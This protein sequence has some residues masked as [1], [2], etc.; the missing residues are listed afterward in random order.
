MKTQSSIQRR[1]PL[2]AAG[3]LLGGIVH[4]FAWGGKL[5]KP[6]LAFP[7]ATD[8]QQRDAILRVLNANPAE[9]LGGEFINSRTALRYAG[10]TASLNRFLS[11]LA[12]CADTRLLIRFNRV[13]GDAVWTVDHDAEADARRF[14]IQVNPASKL[15]D[16]EQLEIPEFQVRA[17]TRTGQ[18]LPAAATR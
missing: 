12:A 3:L 1:I 2:L 9:F 16:L 17:T 8:S 7:E 15:F 13:L 5:T 14:V 11:S 4:T 18:R 6:A 10:S